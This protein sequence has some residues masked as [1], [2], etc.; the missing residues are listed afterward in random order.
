MTAPV[1]PVDV[2][3]DD[4]SVVDSGCEPADFTGFTSGNIALL[5]RGTCPFAVKV[6]N[7][8]AAGAAAAVVFNQGNEDPDDDRF[9]VI[10]GTLGEPG[11]MIPA[12][13]ISFELGAELVETAGLQL[14]V[15]V[16]RISEIR[17]SKNVLA[18]TTGGDPDNVVV[19]GAH[20]DSVQEGP[21]INDNGSGSGGLLEVAEQFK[22]VTPTNTVRFA[23][24]GAEEGG[25]NGSNFYIA[26][27]SDEEFEKLALYLN[28]DMI[29]SPNYVRF[30]YDGDGDA[31]GLAGPPG[32]DAIEELFEDFHR[33]RGLAWEPTQIDFR[34]DYAAF[35]NSGVPFGGLF[36]GAEDP[37]TA[38]QAA[39]YGGTEGEWHDPCYHQACDTFENVDL[40]VFDLNLDA[41]ATAL[42]TYAASTL[43][44]DIRTEVL[45]VAGSSPPPAPDA[46]VVSIVEDAG[47][48][49]TVVDDDALTMADVEA[50]GTVLVSSSVVPATIPAWLADVPRPL[51][52]WEGHLFDDLGLA[53]K[54]REVDSAES[55][56]RMDPANADHPLA[57]GFT[58][59]PAVFD[60]PAGKLNMGLAGPDA[61][62]IAR[63]ASGAQRPVY[64]AY[65][66]GDPMADAS[67]APDDRLAFFATYDNIGR[68]KGAGR[69]MLTAAV[70]W[71]LGTA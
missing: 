45:L 10:A 21:G 25:L 43:D 59:K 20:L 48:N 39:V 18:D 67:P 60:G 4:P 33:G 7:A 27:I 58:G 44:V 16:D 64:F 22:N 12:I 24:W 8:E 71:L 42:A 2:H 3:I 52:T 34:S 36:T 23:W 30:V 54:A 11:T 35:F 55:A 61:T 50:S 37:K 13:G 15:D 56:I 69:E 38:E 70:Y 51:G 47:Y 68:L 19:L 57:A 5:Q 63:E 9:G 41:I 66:E 26:D 46:A 6:A 32:S 28:F 49:V 65:A 53:T 29:A 1:Q 62:V 40:G 17:Q 31:F 14:H